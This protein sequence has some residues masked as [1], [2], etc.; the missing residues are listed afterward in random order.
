MYQKKGSFHNADITVGFDPSV[1]MFNE[2]MGAVSLVLVVSGLGSGI[3][4][5]PVDVTITY[6]DGAEASELS[7]IVLIS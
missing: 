6:T 7:C 4:E 1:Y 2:G 3:L 5:C